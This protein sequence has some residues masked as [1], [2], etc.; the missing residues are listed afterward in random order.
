M[1]GPSAAPWPEHP[2]VAIVKRACIAA[3]KGDRTVAEGC[4]STTPCCTSPGTN[5]LAGLDSL[6]LTDRYKVAT[7]ANWANG[8]YVIIL[9]SLSDAEARTRF[10]YGW[11][12]PRPYIRLVPQPGR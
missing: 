9:P 2:D 6:Q 1:A 10:P 12:A 8:D 7:P 4:S 11:D 3:R 5:P